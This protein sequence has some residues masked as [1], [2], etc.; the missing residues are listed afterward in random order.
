MDIVRDLFE[1]AVLVFNRFNVSAL[2]VALRCLSISSNVIRTSPGGYVRGIISTI[3]LGFGGGLVTSLLTGQPWLLLY[4]NDAIPIYAISYIVLAN[5]P[6]VRWIDSNQRIFSYL[7]MLVDA[8]NR[9]SNLPI[10]L[11]RFRDLQDG[12]KHH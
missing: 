1:P 2:F 6:V 12:G 8:V 3:V 5:T 10:F 4:R 7:F 11:M 9:G